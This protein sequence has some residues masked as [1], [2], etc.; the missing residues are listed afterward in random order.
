MGSILN[1][2]ELGEQ[3]LHQAALVINGCLVANSK[4]GDNNNFVNI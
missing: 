3:Q 2:G 4:I 1:S